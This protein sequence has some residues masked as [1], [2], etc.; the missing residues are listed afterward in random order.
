MQAEIRQTSDLVSLGVDHE[1]E[2]ME[3]KQLF[4]IRIEMKAFYL[5]QKKLQKRLD[6][7]DFSLCNASDRQ[8]T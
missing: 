5:T 8:Y 1:F 3:S 4:G 2:P 7:Y 6:N